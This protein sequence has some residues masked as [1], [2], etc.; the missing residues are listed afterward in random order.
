MTSYAHEVKI[1]LYTISY[2]RSP[3]K[4][5][6]DK[7]ILLM[8]KICIWNIFICV[9]GSFQNSFL[10]WCWHSILLLIFT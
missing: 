10:I 2:S 7:Y 1:Q 5:T 9:I 4:L 6:R 3:K 8:Y